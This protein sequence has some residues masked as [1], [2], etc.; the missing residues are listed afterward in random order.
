[1]TNGKYEVTRIVGY[2]RETKRVY[3][4]STNGD[5][6]TR[7]LFR[8]VN[9]KAGDVGRWG[10]DVGRWGGDVGRWGGDVGRWGGDVGRW[11]GDV[12]RWGGDRRLDSRKFAQSKR[13]LRVL[14]LRMWNG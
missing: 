11:G 12:G 7:H 2:N 9:D 10:G 6:R 8:W 5:P 3:Y 13:R 14:G 1:M 4:I